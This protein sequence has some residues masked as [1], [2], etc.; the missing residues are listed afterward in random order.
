MKL[1]YCDETGTG[2]EP[3]AVMV[4]VVVDS[5]R[6][7][8][9]KEHWGAL[10]SKLSGICGHEL[11]EIHTRDFYA[12]NGVWRDMK[13]PQRSEVITAVFSWLNDR[14]HDVVYSSAVKAAYLDRS[15]RGEVPNE[16]STIWRLLGFHLILATQKAHQSL[17]KTKG[18]TIFVFDNE[19]R[20]QTRFTELIKNPPE[21]SDAYYD[22][23]R[24]ED[25]LSQI[26]DVPYF[27]DSAEVPLLQV[28]DFTAFF[29]RRYAE[30]AEGFTPARYP[31]EVPK[32]ESWIKLLAQR[33]IGR[34]VMYPIKGRCQ[35]A[36]LL[37][38][39]APKSIRE[40]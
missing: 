16:L 11:D 8:V 37:Y 12:G 7:H 19:Y 17:E 29:L 2:E 9:T 10:L 3:V 25:R 28:A 13:G 31:D 33:S 26:V 36:E 20:E 5:Q 38:Q 14:K 18:H 39:L 23:S 40:L 35:I 4:G 21:W 32:I 6:M 1:C 15:Q 30:I 27:G 22:R 24:K 34:S